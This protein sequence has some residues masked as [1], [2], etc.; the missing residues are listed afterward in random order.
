M[1]ANFLIYDQFFCQNELFIL[2]I[3]DI[4]KKTADRMASCILN[5]FNKRSVTLIKNKE[6]VNFL[7][8]RDAQDLSQLHFF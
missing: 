6:N 4:Y 2:I 1:T 8:N 5:R 7:S 3:L